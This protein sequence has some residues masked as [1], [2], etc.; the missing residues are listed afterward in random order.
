MLSNSG[1]PSC[2]TPCHATRT[3]LGA[4][5]QVVAVFYTKRLG[6]SSPDP[7]PGTLPKLLGSNGR[8]SPCL[9]VGV[10]SENIDVACLKLERTEDRVRS[11]PRSSAVSFTIMNMCGCMYSAACYDT[12][13]VV[14]GSTRS[15]YVPLLTPRQKFKY[16][17]YIIGVGFKGSWFNGF[18]ASGKLDLLR[19]DFVRVDL[20]GGH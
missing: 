7:K 14:T 1:A 10:Q 19:V 3:K 9:V 16:A 13:W 12:E 8:S 20:M 5:K 11:R 6:I 2:W 18:W 15:T 17:P 4:T